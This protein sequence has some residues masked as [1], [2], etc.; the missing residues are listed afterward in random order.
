MRPDNLTDAEID[1]T[2]VISCYNEQAFI[3]NTIENVIRALKTTPH[4][5]EIIVVDDV[6]RDNSVRKIQDY[7][8]SHPDLPI[9]LVQNKT[10]LGLAN[11][12]IE[13]AFLGT[14]KYYRLCCGDDS[15]APEALMHIF[16]HIGVADI[17]IPWQ[18]QDKIYGKSF[19]RRILSKTFTFLVNLI[20]G[21][22]IKYYNGM[23][24]HLRYNV[25]RWHPSSYGFGFQADIL[26]RLLDE[27]A[28][29]VQ[30]ESFGTDRKGD[31]ST[32]IHFRNFLSVGHTLLELAIR[33]LRRL[34][35]GRSMNK[36]VEYPAIPSPSR[37]EKAG[38]HK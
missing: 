18:N 7:I 17:V 37:Q 25:M 8:K 4:S 31:D 33:R 38:S 11:T 28:S 29:F 1:I 22:N 19:E 12:Y 15:E 21:Y 10:N 34:L 3:T 30:I 20:S 14:G 36:P 2:V 35:Y 26:T 32:A 27:G 6:S 16:K 9:R 24:V 13:A 5:F 23:A